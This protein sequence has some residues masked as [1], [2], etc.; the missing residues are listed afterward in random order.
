MAESFLQVPP[1]K[2]AVSPRI[3]R[4]VIVIGY[5]LAAVA[6][7]VGDV[8]VPPA[9]ETHAAVWAARFA[10]VVM[11]GWGSALAHGY[12]AFAVS[13]DWANYLLPA[14]LG[15]ALGIL[16]V[17]LAN[18]D[19]TILFVV[20]LAEGAFLALCHELDKRFAEEVPGFASPVGPPANAD[21]A[22]S[23]VPGD[24]D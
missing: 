22:A 11:A 4:A 16:A 13:R 1:D 10:G 20:L 8:F 9:I 19:A 5:V 18:F 17:V 15:A 24:G 12:V 6:F 21:E 2:P 14:W 7:L 3:R 23:N